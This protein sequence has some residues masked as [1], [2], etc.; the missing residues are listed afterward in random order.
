MIYCVELS[1]KKGEAEI[2]HKVDRLVLTQDSLTIDY[3]DSKNPKSI[4][5]SLTNFEKL[6]ISEERQK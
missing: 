6:I 4:I 2:Y 1:L 3:V 5:K